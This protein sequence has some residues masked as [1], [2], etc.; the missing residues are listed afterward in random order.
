MFNPTKETVKWY[1]RKPSGTYNKQIPLKVDCRYEKDE[2]VYVLKEDEFNNYFNPAL[3]DENVELKDKLE[4]IRNENSTLLVDNQELQNKLRIVENDFDA[5]KLESESIKQEL[6]SQDETIIDDLKQKI[7][8]AE[9]KAEK[10]QNDINQMHQDHKDELQKLNE[11]HADEV[12]QLNQKIQDL[13]ERMND[14][15]NLNTVIMQDVNRK[16]IELKDYQNEVESSIGKAVKQTDKMANAKLKEISKWD[17]LWHKDK[18]TLDIQD[19]LD[20]IIA[21]NTPARKQGFL[22]VITAPQ[23]TKGESDVEE[24]QKQSDERQD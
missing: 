16:N 19:E 3:H 24:N 8:D 10:L 11:N 21:D 7:E 6:Q 18:L 5:F 14:V 15:S 12:K 1:I 2:N 17:F 4:Q 20:D 23:I 13:N 22:E 9:S